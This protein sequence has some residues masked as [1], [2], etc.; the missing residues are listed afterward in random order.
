MKIEYYLLKARDLSNN[1]DLC[2]ENPVRYFYEFYEE[3]EN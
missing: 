1:F 3:I 2:T